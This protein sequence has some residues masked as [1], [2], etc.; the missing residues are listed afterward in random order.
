MQ[1]QC[2]TNK[3]AW[4]FKAYEFWVRELGLPDELSK[5]MV[6]QP[7]WYLRR[8]KEYLG[9]VRG[10]KIANLLGSCGKKAVPLALLGADVT[11]VDISVENAQYAGETAAAAGVS[12]EYIVSDLMGWDADCRESNYDIVYMEGGI[13]HYFKDLD[14]LFS[15]CYMLL[16]S[17]GRLVLND[18]HPFRKILKIRDIFDSR[19]DALEV[20]GDY[21]DKELW[22]GEQPHA[23]F[24][25]P[26]EREA[27]PKCLLRYYTM[28]EII[29]AVA[30]AGFV[31]KKLAEGPRF[32]EHKN[33]PGEFT[34]LAFK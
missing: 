24:F 18:F 19:P 20:S 16:K 5:K 22:P 25:S 10:K 34:L 15:K 4:E 8:H 7:E 27:F 12:V 23:K 3:A 33:L 6:E 1:S 32:D 17:G 31:I 30:E 28:G 26:E 14:A 9:D 29:T 11:V 2:E 13:L 21:F